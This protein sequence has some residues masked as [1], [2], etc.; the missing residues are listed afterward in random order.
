MADN[1][2][3]TP[4]TKRPDDE[5]YQDNILRVFKAAILTNYVTLDGAP[6]GTNQTARAEAVE[7]AKT[8][9]VAILIKTPQA[10]FALGRDAWKNASCPD[11][12]ADALRE[13][14]LETQHNVVW[15]QTHG[16]G[17]TGGAGAGANGPANA[18]TELEQKMDKFLVVDPG[19]MNALKS[20]Y[21]NI[22]I[23]TGSDLMANNQTCEAH[24]ASLSTVAAFGTKKTNAF[25]RFWA[26]LQQPNEVKQLMNNDLAQQLRSID[27]IDEIKTRIIMHAS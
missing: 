13:K 10:V 2:V 25:K 14:I 27:P 11:N 24:I 8:N 4:I 18:P 21:K 19:F 7:R 23:K 16:T 6:L 3:P 12:I 1:D 9:G 5:D 15:A 17:P 26:S 22:N 20:H